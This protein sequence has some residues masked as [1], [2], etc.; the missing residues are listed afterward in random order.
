MNIR[1]VLSRIYHI[2]LTQS[3]SHYHIIRSAGDRQKNSVFLNNQ[4]H[5]AFTEMRN[6][7]IAKFLTDCGTS[8]DCP[9]TSYQTA[10]SKLF[11]SISGVPG[12]RFQ[13]PYIGEVSQTKRNFLQY[14]TAILK[15][16]PNPDT[17]V[18]FDQR[19]FIRQRA[20]R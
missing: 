20:V 1:G 6:K 2:N 11:R 8:Y 12:N 17:P 18:E 10:R 14:L 19:S 5:R 13:R 15:K 9:E 3:T 7:G 4:E 16:N